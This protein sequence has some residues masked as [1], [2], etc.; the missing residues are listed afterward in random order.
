MSDEKEALKAL[1][2]NVAKTIKAAQGAGIRGAPTPVT[3]EEGETGKPSPQ[4][5]PTPSEAR[6]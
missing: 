2:G 3:P 1:V 5:Q 6:E 4:V